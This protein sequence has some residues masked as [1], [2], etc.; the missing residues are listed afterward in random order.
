MPGMASCLRRI[1]GDEE[2]VNH[3]Q[4]IRRR[5]STG[6]AGGKNRM[7]ET[8]SSAALRVGGVEAEGIAGGRADEGWGGLRRRCRRTGI[9]EV[10]IELDA[11]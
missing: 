1:A 5:R 6:L 11:G 7:E 9:A 4:A 2:A 8:M 10:P 3:I